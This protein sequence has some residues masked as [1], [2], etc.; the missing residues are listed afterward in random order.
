MNERSSRSHTVFRIVVESKAA[1]ACED[2]G[3]LAGTLSLVD[4]AGSESVRTTGAVGQ[5]AKEGGKINQ[6]LLT[7]SRARKSG[8]EREMYTRACVPKTR[9]KEFSSTPSRI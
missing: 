4:L 7:L 3:L 2:G 9:Q 5:R 8:V 6:S 1:A